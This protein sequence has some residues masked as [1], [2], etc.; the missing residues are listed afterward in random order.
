[1]KTGQIT[2]D[3]GEGAGSSVQSLPDSSEISS[4]EGQQNGG[5]MNRSRSLGPSESQ[6]HR[7]AGS[8]LNSC[9]RTGP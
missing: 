1:M 2:G 6:E 5:I 4:L 9:E 8:R 3:E 7:E